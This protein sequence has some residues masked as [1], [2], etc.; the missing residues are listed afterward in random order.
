MKPIIYL[1]LFFLCFIGC[2]PPNVIEP[3]DGELP[4]TTI[5][6]EVFASELN[7]PVGIASLGGLGVFVAEAGT[8]NN[9][10]Q[11]TF[12]SK[13]GEKFPIIIN[14]PSVRRPDG[15]IE[16]TTHLGINRGNLWIVNGVSGLLYRFSLRDFDI[17]QL[18]VMANQVPSEDIRTFILD[19]DFENDTDDSN[20]YNLTFDFRG[21]IY[22]ADSGANAIIK[23]DRDGKLSVFIALP[24]IP[25]PT[26]V[27]GPTIEPVPTG[28]VFN[29]DRF[30]VCTF[31]GF[32]F[33]PDA[34]RIYEIDLKGN[35][36]EFQEGYNGL[37]DI[38]QPFFHQN[39]FALQLGTFGEMGIVPNSGS[40]V[41][42]TADGPVTVA[43]GLNF[44]NGI[45]FLKP[46]E[47]LVSS[48]LDGN[49]VKIS[50]EE[51]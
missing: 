33:P 2:M 18:P 13:T 44:P 46:N 29:K 9:D 39:L 26:S 7:S 48:L 49:I 27:G 17:D 30:F 14:F 37:I 41:L 8:G 3:I 21:N 43:E 6:N 22:I 24:P 45:G 23:R 1:S 50:I 5:E 47:V 20:I 11:V 40:L 10:G 51:K 34:A 19:F 15:N 35:I 25:N 12:I 31:L 36:V 32:P 42:A 16:G 38:G 28:I 4:P